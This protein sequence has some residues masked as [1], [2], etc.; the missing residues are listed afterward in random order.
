[1]TGS[2]AA[3]RWRVARVGVLGG[4][5][6]L[7]AA[8]AHVLGGGTLPGPGVLLV[9]ALLLGLLATVV[10]VRRCRFGLLA[11]LLAVQQVAL[12]EL[13][14]VAGAVRACTPGAPGGAALT[15]A[16]HAT[17]H[18]AGLGHVV[19]TCV[20]DG[21]QMT[22]TVPGWVMVAAHLVAVLATAWLLARGEAWLWR[23]LDRVADAAGLRRRPSTS[24]AVRDRAPASYVAA[25]LG[26]LAYAVAA[27]RGPPAVPAR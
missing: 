20:S 6:L 3:G 15:H 22:T 23:A 12:H 9:A 4:L 10:T 16:G 19:A 18:G 17:G 7:L 2:P 5:S 27:P 25:S 8:G 1:M 24:A 14:S 13:F 21:M 11:G 26:R